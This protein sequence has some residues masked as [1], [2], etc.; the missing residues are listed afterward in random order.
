M[1]IGEKGQN[2][3]TESY[4]LV[5]ISKFQIQQIATWVLTTFYIYFFLTVHI[6]IKPNDVCSNIGKIFNLPFYSI[7]NIIIIKYYF[8]DR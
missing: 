8:D 4:D 7:N 1:P 6:H 5:H 3:E 2:M